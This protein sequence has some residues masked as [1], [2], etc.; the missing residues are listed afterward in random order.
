MELVDGLTTAKV[1]RAQGRANARITECRNRGLE[2]VLAVSYYEYAQ[3]LQNESSNDSAIVYYMYSEM[4]AGALQFT[5]PYASQSSRYLGVPEH[6]TVLSTWTQLS[7]SMGFFVIAAGIG[8]IA[9]LGIGLLLGVILMRKEKPPHG[10]D[11]F[12]PRSIEDYYTQKK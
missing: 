9:G 1:Q 3:S 6:Q 10:P 2:P 7:P 12:L 4:I 8:A 11:P 5:T